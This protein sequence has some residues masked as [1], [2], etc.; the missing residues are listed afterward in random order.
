MVFDKACIEYN[1]LRKQNFLKNIFTKSQNHGRNITCYRCNKIGHKFIEYKIINAS[2][3]FNSNKPKIK[4]IWVS[5]ETICANPKRP[6]LVWVPKS[7]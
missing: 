6:K 3:I 7:T 1:L 4:Q 5:K 2:K